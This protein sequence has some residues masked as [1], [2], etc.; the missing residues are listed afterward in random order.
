MFNEDKTWYTDKML[1]NLVQACGRGARS[2]EDHC[3]TY[4]LDGIVTDTI[5]RNKDKL[6]KYFIDRFV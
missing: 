5:I 6:P 4:I 1:G 3:V 2:E